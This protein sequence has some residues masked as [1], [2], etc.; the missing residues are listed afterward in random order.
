MITTF[1]LIFVAGITTS[2][3]ALLL[4]SVSFIT[5]MAFNIISRRMKQII[6]S[7]KDFSDNSEEDYNEQIALVQKEIEDNKK[8]MDKEVDKV[9][10]LK[11]DKKVMLE[12]RGKMVEH[13]KQNF[14]YLSHDSLEK[15]SPVKREENPLIKINKY[16]KGR[17]Q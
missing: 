10:H 3:I 2:Q 14:P 4:G 5:C 17:I 15:T 13:I 6:I 12:G 8:D 9:D 1:S 7:N 11:E 16:R